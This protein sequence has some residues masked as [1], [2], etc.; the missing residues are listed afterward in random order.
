[1]AGAAGGYVGLIEQI[2]RNQLNVGELALLYPKNQKV[3]GL[4]VNRLIVKR[5][6]N[7]VPLE[8]HIQNKKIWKSIKNGCV[9]NEKTSFHRNKK[10]PMI[11][12]H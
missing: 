5:L 9:D 8:R 4:N 10:L 2:E 11:F 6:S 1:M 3:T 7:L 12:Y